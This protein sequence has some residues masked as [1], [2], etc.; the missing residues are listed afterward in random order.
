MTVLKYVPKYTLTNGEERHAEHP[1]SFWMPPRR[2]RETLKPGAL[3]KCIFDSPKGA[4]RMWIIIKAVRDDGTYLGRL[5]NIPFWI[6]L[7][8]DDPISFRPEHVIEIF[9]GED[10]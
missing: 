4:E 7:K 9:D 8:L 1:D 2:D 10:A 6:D 5:N 3:V